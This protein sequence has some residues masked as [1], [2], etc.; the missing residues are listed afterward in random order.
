MVCLNLIEYTTKQVDSQQTAKNMPKFLESL[1]KETNN[2]HRDMTANPQL[3]FMD[4]TNNQTTT[5]DKTEQVWD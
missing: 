3:K 4:S 2:T 5:G 1:C